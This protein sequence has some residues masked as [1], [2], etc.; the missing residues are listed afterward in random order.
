MKKKLYIILG[1][2]V[3]LALAV[4]LVLIFFVGSLVTTAVNRYGP[5]LA[6][7]DVHLT[8]AHISPLS[9]SGSL[10]HLTVANPK[11]WS[12]NNAFSLKTIHVSVEP[13]SLFSDHV[14]IK[15]IEIDAPEVLYETRVLTSNI[16]DI[17]KGLQHD[18]AKGTDDAKTKSGATI[19][20]EVQHL[21]IKDGTIKLSVAGAAAVPLSMP[22]VDL[23]NL[24]S[25]GGITSTQLATLISETILKSVVQGAAGAAGKIGVVP[26][27][28]LKSA[29]G[30]LKS[31]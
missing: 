15:E 8:E 9:G 7:T 5:Q 12:S 2:L 4:Y 27:D 30:L 23:H 17:V 28:L 24:G 19:H 31:K 25:G 16:G 26:G 3:G 21:L 22:T 29:E 11:G 20:Y 14:V 6:K 13:S 10:D 18:Q 1:V